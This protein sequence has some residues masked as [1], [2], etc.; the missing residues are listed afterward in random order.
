MNA[1]IARPLY[2]LESI[3]RRGAEDAEARRVILER[4]FSAGLCELCASAVDAVWSHLRS[5][6][7]RESKNEGLTPPWG[8]LYFLKASTAEAQRT[9][10]LAEFS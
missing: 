10:R 8:S 5:F 1:A 6:H 2:F 9:Q 4:H 3:L 7:R